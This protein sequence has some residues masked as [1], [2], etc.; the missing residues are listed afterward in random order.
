MRNGSIGSMHNRQLIENNIIKSSE[1][2][3]KIYKALLQVDNRKASA[4]M[5]YFIDIQNAINRI[6]TILNKNAIA[7]FVIGNTEYK[8]IKINNAEHIAE[9]LFN[10][11][12]KKIDIMKRKI[13]KK[14]LTPY[15]DSK[16]RFTIDS[17]S[18][19]VYAEEFIVIGRKNANN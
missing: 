9:S 1:V 12:F 19:K 10:A 17:K 8:G 3:K 16:G 5:K 7:C 11:N 15:R 4:A 18:R 6:Y 13:S 14:N 2:S